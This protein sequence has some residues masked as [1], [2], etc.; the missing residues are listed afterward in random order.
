MLTSYKLILGIGLVSILSISV[1]SFISTKSSRNEM[2]A[3]IETSGHQLSETIKNSTKFSMLKNQ[4]EQLH[5][6]IDF[7]GK[8]SGIEKVR[9]INKNGGIIYSS[10]KKEINNM[11]DKNAEACYACHTA[12]KPL[13]KLAISETTR[14]FQDTKGVRYLGIINPIYNESS[15]SISSCHAHDPEKKVLGVLDI[16]MSLKD[17]DNQIWLN[18]IKLMIMG[19]SAILVNCLVL[20]FFVHRLIGRPVKELLKAT[21]AVSEGNFNYKVEMDKKH[22]MSNLANAFNTMT[23]KLSETQKQLYQND[24]L[25]SLGQLAAGVAHEINN[26]LTGVL[27]YSSFQLKRIEDEKIDRNDLRESLEVIVR[28]TK[29]CREIVKNLLDFARQVPAKKVKVNI[30]T[31]IEHTLSIIDNQLILHNVNVEKNLKSNIPDI[32]ADKNQIQQVLMN[33][34]INALHATAGKPEGK[35]SITTGTAVKNEK[36][37]ISISVRDNGC[38]I[39]KEHLGN[40]FEPFF[41]TKG[42]K[43]TGLGLSVAW[44]II[45]EHNGMINVDSEPGKG[46][47]FVIYLPDSGGVP[48]ESAGNTV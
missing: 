21:S 40:I 30:N 48:G 29:R 18:Q 14:I 20:W 19:L 23:R 38:G 39:E 42:T 22:E 47:E 13:E 32:D 31:V 2:I 4:N 8:Q 17:V 35:I 34:L 28:E 15:C 45:D 11:I 26:P 27:T 44:G 37:F 33:L 3:L 7:I 10:D 43:G 9:I 36:N 24:K 1:F 12:D 25:A 5:H 6:I 46:T 41:S 16:T